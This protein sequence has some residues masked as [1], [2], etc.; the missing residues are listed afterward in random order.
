MHSHHPKKPGFSHVCHSAGDIFVDQIERIIIRHNFF[1]ENSGWGLDLDDGAANYSI[2]NNL[3]VGVS[4]KL[5]EGSHRVIEN[6]IWVNGANSPCFHVG[7]TDN[8]DVYRR[9]ITVMNTSHAMAENDLNFEMGNHYGEFYTFIRPPFSGKWLETADYNLFY[10]D[11]GEFSARSSITTDD[12]KTP[13]RYDF[14]QWRAMGFDEHS[15]YADPQFIDAENGDYRVKDMSPAIKLGF[16]NFPMD[17][18]G[19][20]SNYDCRYDK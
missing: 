8:H 12:T 19:L 15:V 4:M 16:K 18:F 3:C 2:Y 5:R 11:L 7:N 6:N 13:T 20:T 9:N 14:G 17:E 1:K 10:N